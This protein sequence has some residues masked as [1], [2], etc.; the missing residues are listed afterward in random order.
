MVFLVCF[1]F[2][3]A[4]LSFCTLAFVVF[5]LSKDVFFM[6]SFFPNS[7]GTLHLA[8]GLVGIYSTAAF[9]RAVSK[10]LYFLFGVS[11][12]DVFWSI[13]D[14]FLTVTIYWLHIS[15]LASE[16]QSYHETLLACFLFL[17]RLKKIF[18]EMVLQVLFAYFLFMIFIYAYI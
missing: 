18:P 3:L 16:D 7:Q 9:M 10:F 14:L 4:F 5:L 1:T 8:L 13:L 15:L 17:Y 12:S 6:F 11:L 2:F